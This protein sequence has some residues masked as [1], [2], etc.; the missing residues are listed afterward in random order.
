MLRGQVWSIVRW[1]TERASS[2]GILD[3]STSVNTHGK[4]VLDV[5]KEKHPEPRKVTEKAFLLC[6]DLPPLVDVVVTAAHVE[7]VARLIQG[8]AGP[9]ATMALHW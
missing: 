8:G 6:E 9:G 7:K 1:M 3:P 2:G 4:M 5:L